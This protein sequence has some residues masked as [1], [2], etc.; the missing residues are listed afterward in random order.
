MTRIANVVMW[1]MMFMVGI[2]SLVSA[3]E[4]KN[5]YLRDDDISAT[6]VTVEV[7]YDAQGR[8]VYTY[9]IEAPEDNTG[10][11]LSYELD[12]S[13]TE[14]P[15][16][17]G[18]DVSSYPPDATHS[19]STDEKHVPV[20]VGAP[21]GQ[22][23]LWGVSESNEIHWLVGIE[24]GERA[25]GLQV[26]SPY[27][28]GSREYRLV[29][30]ADYRWDEWDYSGVMEDD[31]DL[32]WLDDWIVAGVTTGPA[33]PGEEYPGGGG[34]GGDDGGD[35]RFPGT[36]FRGESVEANELLTYSTPLR[37]HLH[38][39]AGTKELEMTIH[40]HEAIDSRTF[41]VTPNKHHLRKLFNPKPGTS[42]TVRIPL[43]KGKNRIQLQVQGT[44]EPQRRKTK[45]VRFEHNQKPHPPKHGPGHEQISKDRDV[46]VVR[47]V[48]DGV[49]PGKRDKE[50]RKP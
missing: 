41:Q 35:K 42:E 12:I 49:P 18:F 9:D 15:D 22:A 8:Y 16:A 40:Y 33:C 44:F 14:V 28:P 1:F 26:I 48:R 6:K 11:I 21:W 25:Q 50:H 32:P 39:P 31:P 36:G 29:P 20:A 2:T 10:Y 13:C 19:L 34:G 17:R 45:P 23:G 38:V 5:P 27:P 30:S 4:L 24:P 7:G 3:A 47:V 46:F 37:D 43:E